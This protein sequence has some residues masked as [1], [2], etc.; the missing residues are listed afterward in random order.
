MR[1]FVLLLPLLFALSHSA[2]AGVAPTK[3][4]GATTTDVMVA[5]MI[6]EKGKVVFIDVR[7]AEAF[8]KG[9]IAGAKNLPMDQFTEAALSALVKKNDG[10]LFY[11]DGITCQDSAKATKQAMEWGWGSVYYYRD[12]FSYWKRVGLEVE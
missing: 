2:Y 10:V 12:G 6:H 4:V 9:H 3:V 1:S 5:K 7:S 11:C 8:N